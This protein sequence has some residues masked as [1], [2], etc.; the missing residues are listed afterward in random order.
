MS[1]IRTVVRGAQRRRVSTIVIIAAT[2][3]AVTAKDLAVRFA[4]DGSN[5]AMRVATVVEIL[6]A[7]LVILMGIALLGAALQS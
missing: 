2:T 5:A 6:G 7:L 4:G 3:M 1:A